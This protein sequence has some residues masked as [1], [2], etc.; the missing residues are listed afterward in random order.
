MDAMAA[1]FFDLFKAGGENSAHHGGPQLAEVMVV[2]S[3]V[4][5]NCEL[6]P[7]TNKVV[8]PARKTISRVVTSFEVASAT[9]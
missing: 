9:S 8:T 6:K 1:D 7:N 3:F 2:L 4:N 5:R